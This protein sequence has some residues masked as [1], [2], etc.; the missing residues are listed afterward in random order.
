MHGQSPQPKELRAGASV[1]V[2]A[3]RD[4]LAKVIVH[5]EFKGRLY[6]KTLSLSEMKEWPKS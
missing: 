1:V 3:D 5:V 4:D 6:S 2:P